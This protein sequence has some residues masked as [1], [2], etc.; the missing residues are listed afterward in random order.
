MPDDEVEVLARIERNLASAP[1]AGFIGEGG[2]PFGNMTRSLDEA[3]ERAV[4]SGMPVVKV[5]RG[6]AEGMV[7]CNDDLFISGNNLTATKA[8]MLLMAALL[9]LGALPPAADPCAPTGAELSAVKAKLA[10]YR[11]IFNTH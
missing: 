11:E 5:G 8:R 4:L 10:Q 3:L 6:N 7:P 2:A 9:K 1:L